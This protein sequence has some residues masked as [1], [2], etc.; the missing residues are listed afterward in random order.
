MFYKHRMLICRSSCGSHFDVLW[1]VFG[2]IFMI[3]IYIHGRGLVY[4]SRV[5]VIVIKVKIELC[6]KVYL[7]L[8]F[9][10]KFFTSCPVLNVFF[11][12]ISEHT[13]FYSNAFSK[14]DSKVL[15]GLNMGP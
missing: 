13:L 11:D 3:C 14:L 1:S 8:H 9:A 12:G 7:K 4:Y 2:V 6:L 15:I 10:D 5:S